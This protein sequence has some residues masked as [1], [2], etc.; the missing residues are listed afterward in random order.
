[1]KIVDVVLNISATTLVVMFMVS[2]SA[3]DSNSYIPVV[4]TAIP[5]GIGSLVTIKNALQSGN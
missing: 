1:M 5:L 2:V 3:L 4:G